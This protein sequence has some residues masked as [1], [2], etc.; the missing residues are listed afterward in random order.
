[1]RVACNAALCDVSEESSVDAGADVAVVA[2]WVVAAAAQVS[3]TRGT[4]GSFGAHL[5]HGGGG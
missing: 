5:S 2:L 1:M 4:G 3:C